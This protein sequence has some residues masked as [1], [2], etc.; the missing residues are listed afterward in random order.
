[1]EL[2]NNHKDSLFA[3][4][5]TIFEAKGSIDSFSREDLIE[6]FTQVK[7]WTKKQFDVNK[8]I[9]DNN[10]LIQNEFDDSEKHI[11]SWWGK[12]FN[13]IAGD[14]IFGSG[15]T[16]LLTIMFF[17]VGIVFMI[18]D[19]F[20]DGIVTL[21]ESI[22]SFLQFMPYIVFDILKGTISAK[23]FFGNFVFNYHYIE[24][25]VIHL[26]RLPILKSLLV[27]VWGLFLSSLVICIP[28]G[29]IFA[30]FTSFEERAKNKKI[31]EDRKIFYENKNRAERELLELENE[32]KVIDE[33]VEILTSIYSKQY[34]QN[35]EFFNPDSAQL[36][37]DELNNGSAKT[38]GEIVANIKIYK[39]VNEIDF[40]LK[41][42]NALRD[43]EVGS[44]FTIKI[45]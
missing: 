36:F 31:E 22:Y 33:K 12:V 8:A 14:L 35:K 42:L 24:D 34:D 9:A 1:M 11:T 13:V 3:R 43:K 26:T 37:I 28:L 39:K 18:L 6:Y 40:S 23:D 10:Y 38:L 32:K 44:E 5:K 29:I 45:D 25:A 16:F 20:F 41:E 19:N 7:E 30:V 17:P 21:Y 15:L 4:Y 2:R 27:F